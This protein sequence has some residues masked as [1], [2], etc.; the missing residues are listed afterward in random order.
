VEEYSK[1]RTKAEVTVLWGDARTIS[2]PCRIDGVITSPLY[3]GLICYH[4]QHCYAYELLDLPTEPEILG[5]DLTFPSLREPETT[6]HVHRLQPYPGIFQH[7][8]GG[9]CSR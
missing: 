4:E 7:Q 9:K 6:K 3:V 5:S 8:R 1:L 2:L